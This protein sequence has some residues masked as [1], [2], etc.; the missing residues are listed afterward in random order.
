[1][2]LFWRLF[3]LVLHGDTMGERIGRIGRIRTDFFQPKPEFQAKKAKKSVS[4]CRIR[5]IRSPI[6]PSFSKAEIAVV[7]V[8]CS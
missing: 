7:Q 6:V 8:I 4:I 5:P 2:W 1:L 3:F